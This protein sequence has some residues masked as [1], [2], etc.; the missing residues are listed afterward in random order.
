MS[1]SDFFDDLLAEP[2]AERRWEALSSF[3]SGS[4]VEAM[5]LA[6]TSIGDTSPDRRYVA[7]DILG[8]VACVDRSVAP[9]IAQ[10]LVAHLG[11]EGD[12][13]VLESL[14]VALGHAADP[15]ARPAVLRLVDHP[16]EGVRCAVA[17]AL[18]SLGF[19]DDV[20]AALRLLS[21]DSDDDVRSWATF[22][23]AESDAGDEATIAA[24][25]ARTDDPDEDTRAEGIG[26][27]ARRRDPRAR[28]LVERELA[29]PRDGT[30]LED[31]LDLLEI[32]D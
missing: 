3:V 18:P 23:L 27:L 4:P 7:A 31:V 26:G 6:Q 30:R 19:D 20:T 1:T 5:Q 17:S 2:D 25:A 13:D 28:P 22:G 24:L 15:R 10:Q 21:A 8:Q 9:A 14:V 32:L 12:P 16:D 11:A 29:R